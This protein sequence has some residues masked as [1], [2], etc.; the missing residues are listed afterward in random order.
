MFFTAIHEAGHAVAATVL[1][2]PVRYAT[3]RPR[4][5]IAGV[6]RMRPQR[7]ETLP[8]DHECVLWFAG[9]AAQFAAF[10][11]PT[12]DDYA[13]SVTAA[14]KAAVAGA[15][16]D[17]EWA[18]LRCRA[19]A[20]TTATTQCRRPVADSTITATT[21]NEF[22]AHTWNTTADL[23]SRHW[24]AVQAVALALVLRQTVTGAEI[25]SIVADSSGNSPG[26]VT[27]RAAYVDGSWWL[28]D[29]I[30]LAWT[31]HPHSS[32]LN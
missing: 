4:G 29:H 31:D 9:V 18:R 22:A 11:D 23:I 19:Y 32:V 30:R 25:R 20:I 5:G 16:F 6:V 14:R 27:G 12:A 7:H 3:L 26:D 1:D 2:M 8:I 24:R 17:L 21:T 10:Y 28:P 15:K 13:A